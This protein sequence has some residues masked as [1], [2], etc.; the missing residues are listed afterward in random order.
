MSYGKVFVGIGIKIDIM[1][2]LRSP[3]GVAWVREELEKLVKP[4]I[5]NP[6]IL[7]S[8]DQKRIGSLRLTQSYVKEND[9]RA[10]ET[11]TEYMGFNRMII[12]L[13]EQRCCIV[14]LGD[15][16]YAF[17]YT[18]ESPDTDS[19]FQPADLPDVEYIH[20]ILD[21]HTRTM[22]CEFAQKYGYKNNNTSDVRVFFVTFR[23]SRLFRHGL[24]R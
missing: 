16:L 24:K 23:R 18:N 8:S 9:P 15:A 17:R 2:F 22:M 6:Q 1:D 14:R 4:L 5:G 20:T 12:P 10:V 11:F 3:A 13:N 7:S 21:G 19:F